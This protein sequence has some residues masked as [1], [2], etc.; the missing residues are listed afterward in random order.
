MIHETIRVSL[1]DRTYPIYV[2]TELNS[3]FGPTCEA[4]GIPKRIVVMT[5]TTVAA[6]Y[7]KPLIANLVHFKFDPLPIVIPTGEHQK[8]LRQ[9]NF[10]F[11]NML[12]H[13]IGRTSA[14]VALG[15]GVIGDLAGFV[16]A[17]YHRG[18]PLVQVPTT[19]L[20]QVDSSVGGKVAVN[21]ALGKNMI[22]AF[23]QPKFVWID[24]SHLRTLP[25]RE[26]VC[27]MGEIIKYGIVWDLDFFSYLEMHLDDLLRLDP[28]AVMHVQT[29]CCSIKADIVSKD[30]T[31]SGLRTIL[32]FGHTVGHALE[33]AGAYRVLKHG[34]A[35]LL[36]MVAESFIARELGMIPGEVHQ[37]I[38]DLVRRVPLK[39]KMK[40]FS[41]PAVLRAMGRDKKSVEGIN[42]FVLPTRIGEVKVVERVPPQHIRASLSYLKGIK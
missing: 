27:G 31:E 36:G 32:N 33:A 42:R 30:E 3:L 40:V 29:R 10:A 37:R 14:V 22:G 39:A 24:A 20:S 1:G 17:T 18:V 12:K 35:V 26:V 8:S 13:G 11:T 21:H 4:H 6:R 5:D 19:L 28:Q 41:A 15:G 2:G 25:I 34:E 23:Y 16:A 7:L 9:A 38:V